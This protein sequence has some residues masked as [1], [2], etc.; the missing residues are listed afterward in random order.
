GA[1]ARN[2]GAT[3]LASRWNPAGGFVRAPLPNI[4]PACCRG[5]SPAFFSTSRCSDPS[6]R[7]GAQCRSGAMRRDRSNPGVV[8]EGSD[9]RVSKKCRGSRLV[10]MH[11]VDE[12]G[13]AV[14]VDPLVD[15]VA[16]VEHVARAAAVA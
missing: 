1:L 10:A 12:D 11:F 7:A 2:V 15:A 3:L 16:E 5:S 9:T 8:S 14:R 4:G 6:D 13:H